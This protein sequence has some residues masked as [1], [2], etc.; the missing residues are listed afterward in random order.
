MQL[1]VGT[2]WL[3]R[4]FCFFD[5]TTNMTRKSLKWENQVAEAERRLLIWIDT[6][7]PLEYQD[8]DYIIWMQMYLFPV[9]IHITWPEA[10]KEGAKG[11]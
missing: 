2:K 10:K 1:L 5:L 6:Y 7:N 9:G 11:A 3:E 4:V 8:Q